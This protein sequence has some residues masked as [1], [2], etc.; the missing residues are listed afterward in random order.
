MLRYDHSKTILSGLLGPHFLVDSKTK[1]PIK[2]VYDELMYEP[3][4][5]NFPW[6]KISAKEGATEEEETYTLTYNI[7]GTD[8]YYAAKATPRTDFPNLIHRARYLIVWDGIE[9][10]CQAYMDAEEYNALKPTD[11]L[12]KQK[13]YIGNPTIYNSPGIDSY[14]PNTP[15]V[16]HTTVSANQFTIYTNDQT[17]IT[18]TFRFYYTPD[19]SIYIGLSTQDPGPEGKLFL[20]PGREADENGNPIEDSAPYSEY[21]RV[22]I[23][24]PSRFDKHT[25]LLKQAQVNEETGFAEVTNQDLILFP[26]SIGDVST[27][28]GWGHI[29]HFGL[30]YGTHDDPRYQVPFL[31]GKI[32]GVDDEGNELDGVDIGYQEVPVIRKSGLTI[33]LQ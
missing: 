4:I 13:I 26:E 2:D 23:N 7:T 24:V 6:P 15:F 11:E 5:I 32:N 28:S 12:G 18:H 14:P 31:W 16:I 29:T 22:R 3:L 10:I 25:P 20:E 8:S 19:P 9:Y 30:F 27:E 33:S 1:K 17:E 21:L